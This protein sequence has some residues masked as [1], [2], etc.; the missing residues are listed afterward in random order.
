MGNWSACGKTEET[1]SVKN[2]VEKLLNG[3]TEFAFGCGSGLFETDESNIEKA[4]SYAK[5][6]D[7]IV[8]CVGEPSINS[9]ESHSRTDLRLPFVQRKLIERLSSLKK[10]LI[11]IVFGGRPQVL[12]DIEKFAS[13]ILYVWQPGT[14][15]G[16]AI[17]RMLYGKSV[18]SAKT[19]MSFPRCVGQL[20]LYYNSFNTGHPKENDVISSTVNYGSGYDDEFNSP[21]YPFGFGLSYTRF[22]YS[23]LKLSDTVFYR[24]GKITA[25][26]SVKNTGEFDGKEVVQWYIRDKVAS[27]VRP[28][29]EL[30]GF[31]KIFIKRGESKTLSFVID[32]EKL[33]FYTASKEIKAEKGEFTLFVGGNSRDCLSIDFKLK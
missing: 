17:V 21:L 9:G 23:D 24:G 4:V 3:K 7:V 8:A 25:E 12:T 1:V 33:A 20:P 5:K 32:E 18:P 31:E 19:V 30:K 14:E 13:S 22:E 11:L 26:V 29:K 27:R 10:P 28:V 16:T 15:G 2:G 6:Y